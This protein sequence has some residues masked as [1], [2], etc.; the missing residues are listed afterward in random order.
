MRSTLYILIVL[1]LSQV[2]Y[3]GV[4]A[5]DEGFIVIRKSDMMCGRFVP[6]DTVSPNWLPNWWQAVG[7]EP[8]IAQLFWRSSNCASSSLATCCRQAWY[9]YAGVPIWER[10][11]S[12]ERKAAEFL[13][14]RQIIE[15]RNLAP[16]MYR[17]DDTITRK[18]MMKI[19][20]LTASLPSVSCR[21]S[22]ADVIDDWGCPYIEAALARWFIAH[23]ELFRPD[24]T[25]SQ[26]EVLK[27]ILQARDIGR[28]FESESWQRDYAS[29][30]LYLWLTDTRVSEYNTPATRWWIFQVLARSYGDTFR[31]W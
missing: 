10:S 26:A 30:A 13:A 6:W 31:N 24:D 12:E 8:S 11:I 5:N 19:V 15:R 7:V 20:S 4:F 27:L 2:L 17:L 14:S 18:E 21:R 29:T 22:F 1:I 16:D 25:I 9:R 28:R 23:N 3:L